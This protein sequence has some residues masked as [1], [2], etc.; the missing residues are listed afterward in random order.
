M[1]RSGVSAERVNYGPQ[2]IPRLQTVQVILPE[3]QYDLN[4]EWDG[5]NSRFIA[6]ESGYYQVMAQVKWRDFHA[7][8]PF[9]LV[10]NKNDGGQFLESLQVSPSPSIYPTFEMSAQNIVHLDKGDYVKMLVQ[11]YDSGSVSISHGLAETY[12]TIWRVDEAGFP[13]GLAALVLVGAYV[14]T[15]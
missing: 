11:S 15:R 2:L 13:W 14:L 9:E 6:K 8:S 4:K 1:P 3:A 12:L 7:A 10:V 5:A